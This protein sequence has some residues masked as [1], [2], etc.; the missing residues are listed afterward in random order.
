M[1]CQIA[2]QLAPRSWPV[3]S[4]PL[5]YSRVTLSKY[6]NNKSCSPNCIFFNEKKRNFQLIFDIGKWLWK[7]ELCYIWPSLPNRSI[8]LE[9]FYGCEVTLM[10]IFWR[11]AVAINDVLLHTC[12][13]QYIRYRTIFSKRSAQCLG[14]LKHAWI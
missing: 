14:F 7:P 1:C 12:R 11:Y 4:S 3:Y 10:Y 6:F 9:H 2:I 8:Y 5:M 13:A